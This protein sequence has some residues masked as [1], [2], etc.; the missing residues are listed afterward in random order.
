MWKKKTQDSANLDEATEKVVPT[1][2]DLLW[3]CWYGLVMHSQSGF[4][5]WQLHQVGFLNSY[6][7]PDTFRFIDPLTILLDVHLILAFDF[8]KTSLLLSSSL[9][10]RKEKG[11]EDYEWY[12]INM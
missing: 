5:A 2:D 3:V 11:D 4:K 8:G 7:D 1:N 9:T 12:Y 10:R 6:D